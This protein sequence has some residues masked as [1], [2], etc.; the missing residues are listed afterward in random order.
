MYFNLDKI[1]NALLCKYCEGK[2]DIPKCLPCG[3]AICSI[4][5]SLI[6]IQDKFDCLICKKKHEMPQDGL[7]IMKPLLEILSVKP[8]KVSR[9]KVFDSSIK[10]LDEIQKKNNFIQLGIKNS[11]DFVNEH[12]LNLR[13]NV[14][15]ATEEVILQVNYLSSK[16]IEL[17]DEYEQELIE[18][19]KTNSGSLKSF[20]VIV[21]E[22]E[23]FHNLNNEYLKQH[24]VDDEIIIKLNEKATN[25]I[26]KAEKEIQNLRDVIF[27]RKLLKFEKNKDVINRSILGT[28][29]IKD[30]KIASIIFSSLN[31]IKEL[32][33]LC[34]FQVDQKWTL[35][36]RASRDG[37]EASQFHAKCD[38]KINTLVIIKSEHGNVFG[39]YTEQDWT[40]SDNLMKSDLNSFI[41]SLIN[42]E[43]KPIKLKCLNAEKAIYG[44][45]DYGPA[46][47]YG[48]VIRIHN[49]SNMNTNS[50]SNLGVTGSVYKHPEYAENSA[51]AKSF[52]AG[53]EKF[54]V[55]E[56]EVYMKK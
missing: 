18:F 7:P 49:N 13:S 12:C 22:L 20:D 30:T 48:P 50:W 33:L 56:I 34:E 40:P 29:E 41:F 1:N 6:H 14:Q 19:N 31:Q 4:C 15:L 27:D 54:K 36:Y 8:N 9:G 35:I 51:E 47:G 26:K 3:E 52:L 44:G 43:N 16:L 24:T 17:I 2:L 5:E 28:I 46:F 55:L 21:K 32:M 25:L 39:G 38:K 37:F 11:S 45:T 42:K 23:S 53:S 10:L